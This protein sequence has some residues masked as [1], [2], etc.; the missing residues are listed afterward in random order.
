[1]LIIFKHSKHQLRIKLFLIII[2]EMIS[3]NC[4]QFRIC[5]LDTKSQNFY[6]LQALFRFAFFFIQFNLNF[7]N[8]FALRTLQ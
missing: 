1:M 3:L 2:N 5:N 8:D 7:T 4:I 6:L